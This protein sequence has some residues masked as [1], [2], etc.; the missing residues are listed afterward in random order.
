MAKLTATQKSEFKLVVEMLKE[1]KLPHA[2]AFNREYGRSYMATY[3]GPMKTHYKIVVSYCGK[4]DS[5][6]KK[7]GFVEC[8]EKLFGNNQGVIMPV[9]GATIDMCMYDF[10]SSNFPIDNLLLETM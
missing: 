9:T 8:S 6:K 1:E 7:I 5:F 4:N 3:T 2:F 10:I